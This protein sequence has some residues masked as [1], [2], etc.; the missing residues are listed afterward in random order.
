MS[1]N[2][3]YYLH[4]EFFGLSNEKNVLDLLYFPCEPILTKPNK[5]QMRYW[6]RGKLHTISF[7][8][9]K[10]LIEE[11]LPS[12][13]NG[14]SIS[15]KGVK[16]C[17]QDSL[18]DFSAEFH[19]SP[20][21]E[22][23]DSV[24]EYDLEPFQAEQQRMT[25]E[26]QECSLRAN[27]VLQCPSLYEF[28]LPLGCVSEPDKILRQ[29]IPDIIRSLVN[30]NITCQY[31]GG[32]DLILCDNKFRLNA[33][34]LLAPWTKTYPMIGEL[35][36]KPRSLTIAPESVCNEIKN[37]LLLSDDAIVSISN[38]KPQKLSLLHIPQ[39]ILEQTELITQIAE[40]FVP[41]DITT[42][43]SGIG[44]DR[45][46]YKDSRGTVF[47][48]LWR[49]NELIQK[50]V[51]PRIRND[52]TIFLAIPSK[53]CKLLNIDP[54]DMLASIVS[55]QWA[56]MFENKL[57]LFYAQTPSD[58]D[59]KQRIL[60]AY[61]TMIKQTPIRFASYELLKSLFLM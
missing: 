36:D 46:E 58:M 28:T 35:L 50:K 41:R 19:V 21:N 39:I 14:L 27:Q 31:C 18:F 16:T 9:R 30:A 5:W 33:L 48:T 54:N 38:S 52:Y 60:N 13:F 23:W 32:L 24:W 25:Y 51:M 59:T 55:K 61:D 29:I 2:N 34:H 42:K 43:S 15:A 10:K 37:R 53:Y 45:G 22:I 8:D 3:T 4:V 26:S 49:L 44:Q 6:V 17:Y 12:S 57:D 40:F 56:E 47:V 7:A 1:P 11:K 20:T